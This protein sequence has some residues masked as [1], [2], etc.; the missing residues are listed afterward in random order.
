MGK[1]DEVF[2]ELNNNIETQNK[3]RDEIRVCEEKLQSL[4]YDYYGISST[5]IVDIVNL[6]KIYNNSNKELQ[7]T[8][9]F[10]TSYDELE[11]CNDVIKDDMDISKITK[12]CDAIVDAIRDIVPYPFLYVINN[13]TAYTAKYAMIDLNI[14][15]GQD[16]EKINRVCQMLSMLELL[17]CYLSG[18]FVFKGG[19]K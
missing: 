6:V 1:L 7:D 9:I 4:K 15:S 17:Q 18:F 11:L 2:N 16:Y 12:I 5:P 8:G 13:T 14:R 10:L 3:L 19:K